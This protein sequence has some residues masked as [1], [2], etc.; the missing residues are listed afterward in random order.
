[1]SGG[2]ER[3]SGRKG[4]KS[5]SRGTLGGDGTGGLVFFYC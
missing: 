5:R 2:E 3:D 4:E 1:M